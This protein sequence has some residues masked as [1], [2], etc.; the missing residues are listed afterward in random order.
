MYFCVFCIVFCI[1]LFISHNPLPFVK[2]QCTNFL[3]GYNPSPNSIFGSAELLPHTGISMVKRKLFDPVW[4][5][6]DL[7]NS[8]S[9]DT[10]VV[11]YRV[12]E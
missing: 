9:L 7:H 3:L 1:I 4:R 11:L 2:Q 6:L 12:L 5:I 10:K 8:R